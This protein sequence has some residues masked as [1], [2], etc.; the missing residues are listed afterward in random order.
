M[1]LKSLFPT[2]EFVKDNGE[3]WS[4]DEERLARIKFKKSLA[5]VTINGEIPDD[6][7]TNEQALKLAKNSLTEFLK[8]SKTYK[9]SAEVP[10]V[11][12]EIKL[13][14]KP[15]VR[16]NR[17]RRDYWSELQDFNQLISAS[18]TEHIF[19]NVIKTKED[20]LKYHE[21]RN[22]SVRLGGYQK[23]TYLYHC[24]RFS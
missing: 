20:W 24:S 19:S 3:S 12:D 4:L 22:T 14:G 8:N 17:D 21:L 7:I 6:V 16:G 10:V 2:V 1:K 23:S 18:T 9:S 13:T 5:D 11:A 15:R